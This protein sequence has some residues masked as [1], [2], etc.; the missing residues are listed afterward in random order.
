MAPLHPAPPP[1]VTCHLTPHTLLF[2][3]AAFT[4]TEHMPLAQDGVLSGLQPLPRAW[5]TPLRHTHL[6]A[7]LVDLESSTDMTLAWSTHSPKC[8]VKAEAEFPQLCER[9]H[10]RAGPTASSQPWEL[11]PGRL[12]PG[13]GRQNPTSQGA[14]A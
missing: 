10:S 1:F 6:L 7:E 14:S 3:W 11:H 2:V 12:G 13:A 5:Q 4:P 9:H 8:G